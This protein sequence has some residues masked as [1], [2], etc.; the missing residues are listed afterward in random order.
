MNDELEAAQ[1][2][3]RAAQV[4][5][6]YELW[7]QLGYAATATGKVRD[8]IA[9]E[10]IREALKRDHPLIVEFVEARSLAD[11]NFRKEL[12]STQRKET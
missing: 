9:E 8:Q 11:K 7:A 5:V 2:S 12:K 6:S 4:Y 3:P 10:A 1:S